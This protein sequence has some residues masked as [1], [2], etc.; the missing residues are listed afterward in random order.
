MPRKKKAEPE[1]GAVTTTMLYDPALDTPGGG[2]QPPLDGMPD[3][4][5]KKRAAK[6]KPPDPAVVK[7]GRYKVLNPQKCDVCMT[8]AQKA[9]KVG[10]ALPLPGRACYRRT[11]MGVTTYLCWVHTEEQ[12]RIDGLPQFRAGGKEGQ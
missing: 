8:D 5:P 12:R 2:H 11:H 4:K 9:W 1:A 10:H 3:W 6:R 7:W